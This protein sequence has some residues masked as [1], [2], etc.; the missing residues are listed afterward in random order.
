MTDPKEDRRGQALLGLLLS[1]AMRAGEALEFEKGADFLA[2]IEAA[3][4]S[5]V[6]LVLAD[7]PTNR[8]V[9]S[10][11]RELKPQS[12]PKHIATLPRNLNFLLKTLPRADNGRVSFKS[13]MGRLP[14]A[15]QVFLAA[16]F[17]LAV[18]SE[19]PFDWNVA[20]RHAPALDYIAG[21]ERYLLLYLA[22]CF[23]RVLQALF[24]E[25]DVRMLSALETVACKAAAEARDNGQVDASPVVV[26][27]V[28]L[29]HVNS[30]MNV[31]HDS[32]L[33]Q[34]AKET[35]SHSTV[36]DP[37]WDEHIVDWKRKSDD[38]VYNGVSFARRPT[39]KR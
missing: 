37:E 15:A 18:S 32:D 30:M 19:I 24:T 14:R 8:T 26:A 20:A 17:G 5:Q 36:N 34:V 33:R 28:G 22:L 23:P 7:Q 4:A 39:T 21:L 31:F 11:F 38:V 25:R 1:A 29:A 12:F 16:F 27:V 13:A 6:P 3:E 35:R 9:D 10:M 2:A